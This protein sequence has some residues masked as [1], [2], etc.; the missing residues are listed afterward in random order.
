MFEYLRSRFDSCWGLFGRVNADCCYQELDEYRVQ[1]S[2]CW[3]PS[4]NLSSSNRIFQILRLVSRLDQMFPEHSSPSS[5]LRRVETVPLQ[6]KVSQSQES[7]RC[8]HPWS[9]ALCRVLI[10]ARHTHAML[11]R[12]TKKMARF[13]SAWKQGQHHRL[14]FSK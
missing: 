7:C 1:M 11:R 4:S 8:S 10:P 3:H 13:L 9:K 14:L 5:V 12:T 2:V 6:H